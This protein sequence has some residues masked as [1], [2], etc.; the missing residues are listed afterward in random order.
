M[1]KSLSL[2][3]ALA[4]VFGMFAPLALAAE[5]S[6][7]GEQL[8]KLG[9]IQG[10]NG[11]LME[12]SNWK[13]QDVAVLL[14]R[15]FGEE[16]EAK[17]TEKAHS[18]EDVRGTFYDGY[19]T[20]AANEGLMEGHSP[21]NFGF[22][23]Q[24]TNQQFLTVILRALGY[25][26][27]SENYAEV[28]QIAVEAG[29]AEE[30]VDLKAAAKR[31]DTY[32]LIV[33]A[34][35]S[36]LGTKLGLPGYEITE[37]GIASATVSGA[38]KFQVVFY[39]A[40]D[41]DD[42]SFS[43]KKGTSISANVSEVTFSDDNKT[44]TLEM[45]TKITKGDYTITVAGIGDEAL[46]AKVA[47]ED[48][49]VTNIEFTSLNAVLDRDDNEIVRAN[50]KVYNQYQEDVTNDTDLSVSSG[51]G[52]PSDNDGVL[53]IDG[54][55]VAF[56]RD[57]KINVSALH[58]GTNTFA[59]AV[60]VVVDPA[61]VAD[62]AITGVWH[63][64]GETPEAGDD[65]DEFF[66]L[67]DAKDQYG[68]SMTTPADVNEDV[69]ITNGNT[70]IF[71]QFSQTPAPGP[72]VNNAGADGDKL[73]IQ[74]PADTLAAGTAK[75]TVV[76]KTTGRLSTFDFVVA[77]TSKVVQFDMSSPAVAAAGDDKIEIPFTAVD[78]YGKEV[79]NLSTLT[80]TISLST[81]PSTN[82]VAVGFERDFV[83]GVNKLYLDA[84]G[85]LA[86]ADKV[87]ITAVYDGKVEI[88]TVDL[89][90]ARIPT[91][92][93]GVKDF[94][95]A[96][97]VGAT[98]TLNPGDVIVHD[99]Y[100]NNIDVTLGS[101]AGDYQIK[102]VSAST[103]K[104]S[105]SGGEYT[106]TG[107]VY[108][109]DGSA[110]EGIVFKGESAGSSRITISLE[111]VNDDED[112]TVTVSGSAYTF[113]AKVVE[114]KDIVSYEVEDIGTIYAA[115]TH[116]KNIKVNGVLADGSKV[117]LPSSGYY[118][119]TVTA[120]D[121]ANVNNIIASNTSIEITNTGGDPLAVNDKNE[122][123][124][125][126]TVVIDAAN[127]LP[128]V[129]TVTASTSDPVAT[130]L[131]VATDKFDDIAA[132]VEDAD[133]FIVSAPV[134]DL[135]TTTKVQNVIRDVLFAKDQYGVEMGAEDADPNWTISQF[136]ITNV[137]DGKAIT[138]IDQGDTFNVTVVTSNGLSKVIKFVAK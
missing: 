102:V 51:K 53:T 132:N 122:A 60:L 107:D 56:T 22:D 87:V 130:T 88:L 31:G 82:P 110:N 5:A 111:K 6:S 78:Q 46:E 17:N 95:K 105:L 109:F 11:D 83:K 24:V 27:T 65:A 90:D 71:D 15:L 86:G 40:V 35:D 103:G 25:E 89:E 85:A 44:V 97:A 52:L 20:W 14:S 106:V 26:I 55:G 134:G 43:V 64:D 91:V 92:I 113:T 68:V 30:G 94:A 57:E 23:E 117:A 126:L 58:T 118:T 9:I 38:K 79:T 32:G 74:L 63:A 34:L 73:A 7:A 84:S 119:A 39:Q 137:T 62:V 12:D 115:N 50:Y 69:V 120:G 61:R 3:L 4:L 16:E 41:K 108:G 99:Q 96:Y 77:E 101:N 2:L 114:K 136:I 66:L 121:G 13:R 47:A 72:V 49:R 80:G 59:S 29:I 45:A 81:S 127:V 33:V 100:G 112:D 8:Q 48:E 76:S 36:G 75:I 98:D 21:T 131:H 138:G 125:T 18:Y 42:V 37:Q 1:K 128:I 133:N 104:V 28:D 124:F 54:N 19:L 10:S 116:A 135:N 67:L 129:K 123:T 93:A 70:T